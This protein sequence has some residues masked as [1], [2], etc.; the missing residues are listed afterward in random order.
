MRLLKR[1]L[2]GAALVA[3]AIGCGGGG[4]GAAN[5]S[6]RVTTFITDSMDANDHVWV[7]I[8]SADLVSPTGAQANL[9]D[10]PA[11][12][13]VDL[14]T[15]R[16]LNGELFSLLGTETVP[17]GDYSS[18]RVVLDR[19]VTVF[20][21]GQS[22]GFSRTIAAA[23]SIPGQ[24]TRARVDLAFGAN[25][26]FGVGNNDLVIDFDLA[27]WDDNGT[28]ITPV[29]DE[30]STNGLNDPNRH[31]HHAF[32]GAVSN[33]SGTAPNQS[34]TLTVGGGFNFTVVTNSNTSIYRSSG[35]PNPTLANGQLVVVKGVYST[36]NQALT[37]ESVRIRPPGDD[38]G[39]AEVEGVP[40]NIGASTF[41]V[42]IN[43]ARGFQPRQDLVTVEVGANTRFFSDGGVPMT[44]ADFLAAL[45]TA[46]EVEAEGNYLAGTNR[47]VARKVKLEDENEHE[48][49]AKGAPGSINGAA[50]TFTI[51][52][53]EWN[54]FSG[55]VG[56]VLPIETSGSTTYRDNQ[57]EAMTA[58]AFF[59]AL[60]SAPTV[61]AE[62]R[63][64]DGKLIARKAKLDD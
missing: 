12:R 13:V 31:V 60:A 26:S 5:V 35:D 47:L 57:G 56:G 2:A 22:T 7:T 54:G 33:L 48:A 38:R 29:L 30:G 21:A 40:S 15:L 1:I 28:D 27:R 58:E 42:L 20:A 18:A 51:T 9:F 39:E 44:Q 64:L 50:G 19:Q 53:V 8:Y 41:D 10:D 62:G 25:K 63:Y 61:E 6:G 46:Q 23:F 59:A 3:A 11:G 17:S 4:G 36:A 16:D 52:L 49:E 34:F 45:A 37:A 24:P 32:P 43:R 55:S 14:K